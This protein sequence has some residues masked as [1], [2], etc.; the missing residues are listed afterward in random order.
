MLLAA[1]LSLYPQIV[2]L[3]VAGI[4]NLIS[5]DSVGGVCCRSEVRQRPPRFQVLS[6]H[7]A[8]PQ[9]VSQVR[10]FRY[11][12]GPAPRLRRVTSAK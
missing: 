11:S 5:V 6:S 2:Q 4:A 3:V 12:A 9:F 10:K 1:I 7:V 8:E